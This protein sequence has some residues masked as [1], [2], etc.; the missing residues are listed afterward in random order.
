MTE[1]HVLIAGASR[2]LGLGLAEHLLA[3]GWRVTATQRT[4]S[5]G[6]QALARPE[7]QVETVDIDDDGAVAA[8]QERL[9]EARYD[10]VFVVAGISNGAATPMPQIS[11][12]TAAQI[13]QTNSVSPIQFAEAFAAQVQPGGTVAFMTSILGSV[14]GN[15]RGGWE[16][17]RASKAALNTLGRSFQ[18]RHAKAGWDVVLMH[19]GWVRTDM[20]GQSADIDTETSV[21]G[22]LDVLAQ[23][24]RKGCSYLDYQGRTVAW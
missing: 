4:A 12:A 8:L 6:L 3:R 22:M 10:L 23:T 20:G 19:P 17:Y 13:F 15:T 24:G 2:G 18:L 1:K 9:A 21:R 14:S 16:V 7:L 5:P 11:R